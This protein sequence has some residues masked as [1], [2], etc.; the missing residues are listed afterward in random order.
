MVTISIHLKAVIE[1]QGNDNERVWLIRYRVTEIRYHRVS[2]LKNRI[3]SV[4]LFVPDIWSCVPT[5]IQWE[6]IVQSYIQPAG[7][8]P[9]EG[10]AKVCPAC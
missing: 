6:S 1:S 7:E 4:V 8:R 9:G 2:S 10:D 3:E 5:S